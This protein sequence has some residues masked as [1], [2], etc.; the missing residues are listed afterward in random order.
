MAYEHDNP[1][2]GHGET[3]KQMLNAPRNALY[4]WP[5]DNLTAAK[6]KA[7]GLF[8]DDLKIVGPRHL[9]ETNFR[10]RLD[11]DVVLDHATY[12]SAE[13]QY[14]LNEYLSRRSTAGVATYYVIEVRITKR[15]L[16]TAVPHPPLN[17][18]YVV[19]QFIMRKLKHAGIPVQSGSMLDITVERG[20]ISKRELEDRTVVFTWKDI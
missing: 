13:E 14:V 11:L 7:V 19:S 5:N 16:A 12:L 1:F 8:R 18:A 20:T 15:E 3:T 9:V 4:I 17:V 6:M 2:R 10:G